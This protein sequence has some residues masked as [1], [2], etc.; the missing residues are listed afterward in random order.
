[1]KDLKDKPWTKEDIAELFDKQREFFKSGKTLDLQWRKK[2]LIKLRDAMITYEQEMYDALYEDLGRS[3]VEAFLCDLG[4]VI[5]ETN[6]AIK[7]LKKWAKPETHFSGFLTFPS[8][9]TKVYKMP[10]GVSLIIS[11]YNFPIFLTFGV[12]AAA[13]AGGNTAVIKASSKSKACTKVMQKI[14]SEV[15]E[16]EFVSLVDGGHDI[17]D[18]CLAERSD[19]IFYTGSPAVAKHVME[20]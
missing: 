20:E 2:Q 9:T 15:F 3:D 18:M 10:Y 7:N 14:I 13:I 17:A 16:P 4:P 1:M 6:E 5:L 19:K 8:L 11:P 12:L